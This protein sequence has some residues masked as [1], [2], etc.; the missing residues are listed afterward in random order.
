MSCIISTTFIGAFF[1]IRSGEDLLERIYTG[2]I[3]PM[4]NAGGTGEAR[5]QGTGQVISVTTGFIDL[6][7]NYI[8]VDNVLKIVEGSGTG[9]KGTMHLKPIV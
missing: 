8:Y 9:A 4:L 7:L 1:A 2:N 3:S 6:F 5:N